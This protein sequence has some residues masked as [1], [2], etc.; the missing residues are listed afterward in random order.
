MPK[1]SLDRGNKKVFEDS[2]SEYSSEESGESE[3]SIEQQF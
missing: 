2:S 3:E 1:F